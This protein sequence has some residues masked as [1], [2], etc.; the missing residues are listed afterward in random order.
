MPVC[1][2][3]GTKTGFLD[4]RDGKCGECR[5]NAKNHAARES[6]ERK[7]TDEH[8]RM[9]SKARAAA[10]LLTTETSHNLP[11]ASRIGIVA[12]ERVIGLN[13]LKDLFVE[14]RDVFGGRSATLEKALQDARQGAL[15]NLGEKALELGASAV[16][17]VS[18][19]HSEMTGLPGGGGMILVVATGTAV[20]LGPSADE[21]L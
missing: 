6:S 9:Q 20:R 4:I 15:E 16:V 13:I 17:G 14:F 5:A 12:A 21:Q 1:S 2:N 8:S 11:V 3:C 19:T 10:I 7:T 18:L